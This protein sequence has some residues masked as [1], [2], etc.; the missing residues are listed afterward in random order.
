[1]YEHTMDTHLYQK[2][3]VC[4]EAG[5]PIIDTQTDRQEN[6]TWGTIQ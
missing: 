6:I 4:R 2:S 3:Q 1:M 5:P